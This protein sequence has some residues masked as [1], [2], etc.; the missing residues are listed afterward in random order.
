V[1]REVGVT[2]LLA[3]AFCAGYWFRGWWQSRPHAADAAASSAGDEALAW[4]CPC[5][6]AYVVELELDADKDGNLSIDAIK[7]MLEDRRRAWIVAH[8]SHPGFVS[9]PPMDWDV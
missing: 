9:P 2:I 7:A 4:R 8:H 5:G 3:T 6:G 1:V